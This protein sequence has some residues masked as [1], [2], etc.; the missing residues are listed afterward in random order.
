[1]WCSSGPPKEV[2]SA[3]ADTLAGRLQAKQA[4]KGRERATLVDQLAD[5]LDL[6][7]EQRRP[8][9]ARRHAVAGREVPEQH[10]QR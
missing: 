2:W 8:R 10:R 3:V 9:R 4:P 7:R 6:D 5:A 1:M